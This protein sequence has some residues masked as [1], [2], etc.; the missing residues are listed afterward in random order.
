MKYAFI[1][2]EESAYAVRRLCKVMDVHPSGYYAWCA[3]PHCAGAIEDRRLLGH[4]KHA[5]LE[6]GGV[7]LPQGP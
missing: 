2:A 5:W 3:K 6:S 1:K 4:I 7:W